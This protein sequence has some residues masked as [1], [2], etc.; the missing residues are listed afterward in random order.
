[1]KNI[2]IKGR[3]TTT[4]V[5]T[6][7]L[8]FFGA[9]LLQSGYDIV[10]DILFSGGSGSATV[11]KESKKIINSF[12]NITSLR[13]YG[14]G[15]NSNSAISP[16]L[17]NFETA[18]LDIGQRNVLT[19]E[20]MMANDGVV[21]NLVS[22]T[23][24]ENRTF[25][26]NLSVTDQEVVTDVSIS[27]GG[28]S[29]YASTINYDFDGNPIELTGN[30]YKR[31]LSHNSNQPIQVE[32]LRVQINGATDAQIAEI[33]N[34]ESYIVRSKGKGI[35]QNPFYLSTFVSPESVR[36]DII[37]VPLMFDLEGNTAVV[38]SNLLNSAIEIQTTF[39]Y[40]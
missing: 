20:A 12:D 13:L 16:T 39:F 9:N 4:G 11:T 33:I 5:G 14:G 38:I 18:E 19:S 36:K 31:L 7:P 3:S 23:A 26:T 25:A 30:G 17:T 35:E 2:S 28:G 1:M 32:K 6:Y 29:P 27:G 8:I 40:N 34:S 15:T 10:K 37:D 21:S 22:A 24:V